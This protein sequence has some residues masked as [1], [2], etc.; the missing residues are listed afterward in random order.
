MSHDTNII[1]VERLDLKIRLTWVKAHQDRMTPYPN[2]DMPAMM[3]TDVDTL[4]E[5]FWLLMVDGI[6]LPLQQGLQSSLTAV[7]FSIGGI[8]T[9]HIE[10]ALPYKSGSTVSIYRKMDGCSL[11]HH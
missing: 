7:T 4:A 5:R 11:E 3:N 2:L 6:V 9:T 1:G 10:S 8:R